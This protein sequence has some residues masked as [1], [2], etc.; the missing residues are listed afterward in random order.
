[1]RVGIV[2][3]TIVVLGLVVTSFVAHIP[4]PAPTPQ[5]ISN[6]QKDPKFL[7][8]FANLSSSYPDQ[9]VTYSYTGYNDVGS[10][11]CGPSSPLRSLADTLFPFHSLTSSWLFFVLNSTP[12]CYPNCPK[13]VQFIAPFGWIAV[14]VNPSTG[15][16]Y[17]VKFEGFCT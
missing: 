15:E 10:Y 13:N 4:G 1:M 16:V 6:A 17:G 9:N 12:K 8:Y 11:P 14:E 3:A 7:R 5:A 2:A